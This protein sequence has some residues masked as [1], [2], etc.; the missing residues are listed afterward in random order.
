MAIK[1]VEPS[2]PFF[3]S[4]RKERHYLLLLISYKIAHSDKRHN[5]DDKGILEIEVSKDPE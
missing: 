4:N 5:S 2:F 3:M 1:K